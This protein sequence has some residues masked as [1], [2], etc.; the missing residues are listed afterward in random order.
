MN[1]NVAR[2]TSHTKP[3]LHQITFKPVKTGLNVGGKARNIAI[4]LVLQQY[5]KTCCTFF[6]AR[7][8]VP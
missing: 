3:V 7:F 8:S 4:E 2:F 6:V 5:C 1:S